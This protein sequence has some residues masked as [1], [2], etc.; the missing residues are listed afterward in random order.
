MLLSLEIHDSELSGRSNPLLQKRILILQKNIPIFLYNEEHT[1]KKRILRFC[2]PIIL[3]LIITSCSAGD[4]SL[5]F[6]LKTGKTYTIQIN[7]QIKS[8]I[9]NNNE[10]T[11]LNESLRTGF[12]FTPLEITKDG[13]YRI[14]AKILNI[15]VN[16]LTNSGT[17]K[18]D[19]ESD[20]N[21]PIIALPFANIIN[22]P[23]YVTV[24]SEGNVLAVEG[25]KNNLKNA[26]DGFLLNDDQIKNF[27]AESLSDQY[28]DETL[29]ETFERMFAFYPGKPVQPGEKW[30]KTVSFTNKQQFL[31]KSTYEL[32]EQNNGVAVISVNSNLRT[33]DK[34]ENS[35]KKFANQVLTG[36][37]NGKLMIDQISGWVT[38]A[39]FNYKMYNSS[40]DS[41]QNFSNNSPKL[42]S[43]EV[44]V[45][46]TP[47]LTTAFREIV[48]SPNAIAK[49]D[50]I[51]MTVI[52][53][54][55]VYCSLVLLYLVFLNLSNFIEN[56]IKK[57]SKAT[58]ETVQK[59][60]TGYPAGEMTG[61]LNAA[62]AVALHLYDSEIHDEENTILTI[63]RAPRFYSPWSSKIYGIR[64]NPR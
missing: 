60:V 40:S 28:S 7:K 59:T 25:M 13:K 21:L 54:G 43:S 24:S 20:K 45:E 19:S 8:Y 23:F 29:Q 27:V 63:Q 47:L 17:I 64:K 39:F 46:F 14:E 12:S 41:T 37:Q 51:G 50:G 36:T 3:S 4:E 2:V 56:R 30:E 55:V 31:M 38:K 16:I 18:Y 48:W 58:G 32:L 62:I 5:S 57:G 26:F 33:A 52:G 11:D 22:K 34:T 35:N 9:K 42:L 53:M 6:S 10:T 49:G 44:T 1:M 15:S 61:E